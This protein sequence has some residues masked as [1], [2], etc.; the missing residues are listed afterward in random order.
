MEK[1]QVQK[2][3]DDVSEIKRIFANTYRDFSEAVKLLIIAGGFLV[4]K[5]AI[6][7]L[8]V[9]ATWNLF[10][11]SIRLGTEVAIVSYISSCLSWI[12][13]LAT[14]ATYLLLRNKQK[15]FARGLG[16]QL[17]DMWGGFLIGIILYGAAVNL[18]S[19]H[20]SKDQFA[21]YVSV[22]WLFYMVSIPLMLFITGVLLN[23]SA[24]K[25]L[26][27]LYIFVSLTVTALP[28]TLDYA[29]KGGMTIEV[30]LGSLLGTS[31]MP[32]IFLICTG[33]LLG[34]KKKTET[35]DDNV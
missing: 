19:L 6:T 25:R 26:A 2:A 32:G 27:L 7:S 15:R 30:S 23:K 31:I 21:R 17:I 20:L 29:V 13:F 34:K 22:P 14:L 18:V 33:Y 9:F 12:G 11:D 1:D 24:S 3:L 5:G 10:S 8:N 16:L 35:S 4:A 28:L